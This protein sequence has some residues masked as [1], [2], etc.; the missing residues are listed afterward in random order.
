M[1]VHFAVALLS[2]VVLNGQFGRRLG[3]EIVLR[4]RLVRAFGG[5]AWPAQS[6][7]PLGERLTTR[8]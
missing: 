2:R 6:D 3:A 8:S 1:G 5:V 4:P 7:A